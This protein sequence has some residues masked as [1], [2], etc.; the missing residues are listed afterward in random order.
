LMEEGTDV[1]I[2]LIRLMLTA[3][4]ILSH[5]MQSLPHVPV[6]FRYI[7]HTLQT[8]VMSKFPESRHTVI[9][10]F[11]FLRF[12]NPAINV[13]ESYGLTEEPPSKE[14]RRVFVLAT[15][16]LQSLANNIPMGAKEE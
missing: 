13:P 10:G 14:A 15:K 12:F 2:N 7:C 8:A 4:Q 11:I 3:Q 6:P 5:I 1:K 16:T 9:G